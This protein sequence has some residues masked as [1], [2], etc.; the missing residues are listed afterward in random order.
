MPPLD[1]NDKIEEHQG[2]VHKLAH[3]YYY[4]STDPSIGFEDVLQEAN[5]ALLECIDRFDPSKG[6]TFATFAYPTIGGHLQTYLDRSTQ[7]IRFPQNLITMANR[8]YR[9]GLDQESPKDI[10]KL[11]ECSL[12]RAEWALKYLRL[13]VL[14]SLDDGKALGTDDDDWEPRLARVVGD[15]TGVE[16]EEFLRALK[17]R[18]Q[19]IAKRLLTGYTQLEIAQ[20]L[21]VSRQR[22]WLLLQ[23]IK[24]R[25]EGYLSVSGQ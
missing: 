18:D 3:K 25:Y 17:P 8:I 4:R 6:Y 2:L 13:R 11:L 1:I 14:A 7:Q 16:I 19:V 23:G 21:N 20:E 5:I 10:A 22:V 9:L 15:P 24:E 12:Y